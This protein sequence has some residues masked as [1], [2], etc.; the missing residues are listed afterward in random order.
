MGVQIHQFNRLTLTH[1]RCLTLFIADYCLFLIV[2]RILHTYE[3][4]SEVRPST[5]SPNKL[6]KPHQIYNGHMV[7]L[8]DVLN[9]QLDAHLNEHFV[10][11][12]VIYHFL[13]FK[14]GLY[15]IFIL[16]IYRLNLLGLHLLPVGIKEV[17]CIFRLLC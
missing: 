1:L 7:L 6:L 5:Y 13:V 8:R 4:V 16:K 10:F 2:E 3:I 15:F 11:E 14:L 17:I 12:I 9:A